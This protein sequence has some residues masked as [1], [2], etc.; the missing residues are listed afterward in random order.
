[1]HAYLQIDLVQVR[2]RDREQKSG[3]KREAAQEGVVR[4]SGIVARAAVRTR[5]SRTNAVEQFRQNS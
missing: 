3:Q 5:R 1:M 2:V 4:V